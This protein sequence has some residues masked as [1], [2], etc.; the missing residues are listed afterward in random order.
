M[1]GQLERF[2]RVH[3]ADRSLFEQELDVAGF[4]RSAERKL[5]QRGRVLGRARQHRPEGA[6]VGRSSRHPDVEVTGEGRPSKQ[7]L[8]SSDPN[9]VELVYLPACKQHLQELIRRL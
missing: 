2:K 7:I 8:G 5:Q 9:A 1:S 6:F 3:S 4:Y